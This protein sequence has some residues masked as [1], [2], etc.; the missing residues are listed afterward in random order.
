[1]FRVNGVPV[2]AGANW[3]LSDWT[4]LLDSLLPKKQMKTISYTGSFPLYSLRHSVQDGPTECP[5][6][7][8]HCEYLPRTYEC[9]TPGESCILN[10]GCRC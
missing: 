1:M 5:T 4:F 9:C 7:Q 6:G 10:V 2:E 3:T 8:V